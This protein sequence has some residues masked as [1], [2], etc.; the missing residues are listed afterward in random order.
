[1]SHTKHAGH[2][3]NLSQPPEAKQNPKAGQNHSRNAPSHAKNQESETKKKVISEKEIM[4]FLIFVEEK[5]ELNPAKLEKFVKIFQGIANNMK[6]AEDKEESNNNQ[7]GENNYCLE[8]ILIS[9]QDFLIEFPFLV[10][11]FNKL[12]PKNYK[13]AILSKK[14]AQDF[15]LKIKSRDEEVY[16]NV[17]GYLEKHKANE[18]E[19][20]GLL[21]KL[22]ESL[23]IYPDLYEEMLIIMDVKKYTK[24]ISGN[25]DNSKKSNGNTKYGDTFHTVNQKKNQASTLPGEDKNVAHSNEDL[26]SKKENHISATKDLAV[27]TKAASW[28]KDIKG[29][30]DPEHLFFDNLKNMLTSTQY[31]N[32]IKLISMYTKG[33]FCYSD[34]ALLA[35]VVLKDKQEILNIIKQIAAS[36]I[37]S[38]KNYSNL[39]KPLSDI[40]FSSK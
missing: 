32:L 24:R 6:K 35:D 29:Q 33:I 38:R 17:L 34:F 20:E 5:F 37:V 31:M 4:D 40:D 25:K 39:I 30:Q 19:F 2:L 9:S 7:L 36:K 18:L 28:K 12:L 1:M 22:E 3:N 23:N 14:F 11:E 16:G 26:D 13:L 10:M 8:D 27:V 15:L 21:N